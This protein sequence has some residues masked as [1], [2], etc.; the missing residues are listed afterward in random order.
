MRKTVF[1]LVACML[2]SAF[3]TLSVYAENYGTDSPNNVVSSVESQTLYYED[4]PIKIYVGEI[5]EI[6]SEK[7]A[8]AAYYTRN[9]NLPFTVHYGD[10]HIATITAHLTTGGIDRDWCFLNS[11]SYTYETHVGLVNVWYWEPNTVTD[12]FI[13]AAF[14]IQYIN[15]IIG[16]Q[17][18]RF[19]CNSDNGAVTF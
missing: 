18:I 3:L 11:G 16:P 7:G 17:A 13:Q 8:R 10:I 9:Y 15:N 1:G 4:G 12:T 2:M 19:Y 6:E 14:K 5:T